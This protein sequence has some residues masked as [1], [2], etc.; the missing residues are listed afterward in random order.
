MPAA[1]SNEYRNAITQLDSFE[2]KPVKFGADK[3]TLEEQKAHFQSLLETVKDTR[4]SLNEKQQNELDR[5]IIGLRYRMEGMNGGL[6]SLE[7]SKVQEKELEILVSLAKEWKEGYDRY[8]VTKID[9]GG[10]EEAKLKQ[11]CCYPEFVTLLEVDKSLRDSFFRWALRDNCGVNEFVQ[12]PA[13]CTKL[14]EAYLAGR[15]GLFAKQFKWMDRQKVGEGVVEE[16]VMTLP[17]MT[18]NGTKLERKSISILDEDRKVNLKGNFEV[19]IKEVFEVFSKKN[20]NPGYLEFFGENGIENWSVDGLEW[21]DNDNKRAVQVDIS[22][23]NS[24]W[25]K[26]LPVFMTLSKEDLKER[27][28]IEDVPEER[29]WIVVTKATRETATL[30]VDKSHGYTEVLIPNDDGTYICYPFGKYPIKF[31]TTMLQQC[32]FIADTVEAR[33]QYPDENPF[34]SQRQQ[35]ATPYFINADK[36]RRF[37]EE[38]RRELVKAQKGN[39]IFQFA[40]ENCAWWAQNL[41]E[42]LFGPK[43][44]GGPIPNYFRALVFKAEPMIE[45]LKSVFTFTRKL[46]EKLKALVLRI[47]EFCFMSWRG[48]TVAENGVRVVKSIATSPFR[49]YKEC[50]LPGNLHKRI[51]KDKIKGGVTFG[52][53][54]QRQKI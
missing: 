51:Q 47:V 7:F 3:K 22:K 31:P 43:D 9:E 6:D 4:N 17:F 49:T 30:D 15:V 45:P 13:T 54:F 46:G 50:S 52:H 42:K 14:K 33:I 39:V 29:Q 48:F 12:F 36:G 2:K 38:I 10:E 41:L 37:M 26:E 53:L 32:L 8:Q 23:R 5:R 28:A 19:S 25:W 40:W 16:K 1:I 11:A 35:A 27:Y 34:F 18:Q 20:S 21:W 44:N 24:E